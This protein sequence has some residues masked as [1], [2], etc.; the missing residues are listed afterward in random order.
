MS[1]KPTITS[2]ENMLPFVMQN[3]NGL[4]TMMAMEFEKFIPTLLKA[5]GLMYE[6]TCVLSKAF[7]RII[8]AVMWQWLNSAEI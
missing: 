7:T 5:C 4:G 8:S 3:M 1:G 2:F 6:I